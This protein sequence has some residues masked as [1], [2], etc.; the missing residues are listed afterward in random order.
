LVAVLIREFRTG[1]VCEILSHCPAKIGVFGLF[2]KFC[3][4]M[5]QNFWRI[6][7]NV[8]FLRHIDTINNIIATH[9]GKEGRKD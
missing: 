7:N 2:A 5:T 3:V 1:N 9:Y 6:Q 8:L 4:K